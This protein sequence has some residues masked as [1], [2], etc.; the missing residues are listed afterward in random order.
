[1]EKERQI[2]SI[3]E[4]LKGMHRAEPSPFFADKINARIQHG[5][6]ES[7]FATESGGFW[8]WGIAF[9]MSALLMLNI[10]FLVQAK[11]N[12]KRFDN[13]LVSFADEALYHI[14]QQIIYR[15]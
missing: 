4:S 12:E 11:L 3:M 13:Q 14:N 8:R 5:N 15:Y 6:F 9:L 2:D 7:R 10:L 1:M